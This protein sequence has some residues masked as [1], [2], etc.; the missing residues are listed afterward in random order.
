MAFFAAAVVAD[1]GNGLARLDDENEAKVL[2]VDAPEDAP[3]GF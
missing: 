1:D 3:A 2:L